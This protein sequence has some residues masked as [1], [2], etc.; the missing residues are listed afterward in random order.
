MIRNLI[1][2]GIIFTSA[3]CL[4]KTITHLPPPPPPSKGTGATAIYV[5]TQYPAAEVTS[6]IKG[7]PFHLAVS[8]CLALGETA[9]SNV[10]LTAAYV[11]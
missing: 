6:H 11:P 8:I 1:I 5:Y 4:D 10:S 9:I 7:D 2:F 3:R